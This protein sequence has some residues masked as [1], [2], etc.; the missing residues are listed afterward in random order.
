MFSLC[1]AACRES[2]QDFIF[3]YLGESGGLYWLFAILTLT[4]DVRNLEHS[5]GNPG[6]RPTNGAVVKALAR[7]RFANKRLD[8]ACSTNAARHDLSGGVA[9]ERK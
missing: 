6:S 4:A 3:T 8:P 1:G 9:G 2:S 7:V 5:L